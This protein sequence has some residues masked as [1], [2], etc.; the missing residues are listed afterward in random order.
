MGQTLLLVLMLALAACAGAPAQRK[1]PRSEPASL[2][3]KNTDEAQGSN[4]YA[5]IK[6]LLQSGA[7]VNVLVDYTSSC[8]G[9]PGGYKLKDFGSDAEQET[10][11]ETEK[12]F[13]L[14]SFSQYP[15]FSVV[16]RSQLDRSIQE[17]KLGLN[18]TTTSTLQPGR[19]SGATHLIVIEAKYHFDR[20]N[21]KYKGT[22]LSIKKFLD[23]QK[24]IIVAMDRYSETRDVE[25]RPVPRPA[26]TTVAQ[27]PPAQEM[28]ELQRMPP[29]VVA[30]PA[31]QPVETIAIYGHPTP[32]S[33]PAPAREV[34]ASPQDSYRPAVIAVPVPVPQRPLQ[35]A[36]RPWTSRKIPDWQLARMLKQR[37]P[38]LRDKNDDALVRHF[39]NNHPTLK[40]RIKLSGQKQ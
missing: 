14:E 28:A 34:A 7:T 38:R 22:Y 20:V 39:I 29:I 13:L 37:F 10:V 19:I 11:I 16:D 3:V 21:G 9:V 12:Y 31:P 36:Y 25:Y 4:V 30:T 33:E 2:K 15:A 35:Q 24:D 26:Q 6:R 32:S 8:E 18:G 27:S 1:T 23:I 5:S 40:D 17:I